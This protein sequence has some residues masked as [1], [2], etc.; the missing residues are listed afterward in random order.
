MTEPFDDS[1]VGRWSV[2]LP[3]IV[4]RSAIVEYALGTNDDSPACLSGD[5][6][7]PVFAL[8]PLFA[9]RGVEPVVVE[10]HR[11]EMAGRT[12]HG[13]HAMIFHRPLR[14]GD[15]VTIRS[16]TIGIHA[17][18]SGV[19]A[20]S[21]FETRDVLGGMLNEQFMTAYFRGVSSTIDIGENAPKLS[22]FRHTD[23]GKL[24]G[25]LT[26]PI[27]ADQAVRYAQASNDFHN[28][29]LDEEFARSVGL[30]GAVL[31]GMCLLAFATRAVREIT[32]C[33][34]PEAIRQLGCRFA[35]PILPGDDVT[36]RVFCLSDSGQ[37]TDVGFECLNSGG[38][39]VLS[40]GYAQLAS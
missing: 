18:S 28:I 29:H 36:T 15:E 26:Y 23:D 30:P 2:P 25:S 19:V 12:V 11:H 33:S 10:E 7:P 1:V 38:E 32:G 8:V 20:I 9:I 27:D 6:A 5:V 37:S 14:P 3:Y 21:K 31:H 16:A 35:R 22:S 40:A 34:G 24:I 13:E 4:E 17:R 39:M